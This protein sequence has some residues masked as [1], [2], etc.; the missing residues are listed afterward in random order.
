MMVFDRS[1][2]IALAKCCGEKSRYDLH[3]MRFEIRGCPVVE[4]TATNARVLVKV[5]FP[6]SIDGEEPTES[7]FWIPAKQ[8]LEAIESVIASTVRLTLLPNWRV[9]VKIGGNNIN[10]ARGIVEYIIDRA[11]P[12]EINQYPKTEDIFSQEENSV[13]V[14]SFDP[15]LLATAASVFDLTDFS[16]CSLKMNEDNPRLCAFVRHESSGGVVAAMPMARKG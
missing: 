10:K 16:S 8:L 9:S 7:V 11:M 15:G 6:L 3:L 13:E 14:G 4:I 1:N 5:P 2:L 12:E